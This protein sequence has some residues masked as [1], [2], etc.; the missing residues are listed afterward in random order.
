MNLNEVQ[1]EA[2]GFFLSWY[3]KDLIFFREF[4]RFAKGEKSVEEYSIDYPGSFQDFINSYQ[5]SRTLIKGN[6]ENLLRICKQWHDEDQWLEVNELAATIFNNGIVHGRPISLASKVMFLMRPNEVLPYDKRAR[7]ALGMKNSETD[8]DL[9]RRLAL[10]F[11]DRNKKLIDD[12]LVLAGE[13]LDVLESQ[14]TDL[15]LPM[16]HIRRLRLLDKLL[17]TAGG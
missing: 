15:N 8:Y 9:F 1:I 7:I 13:M 6:T 10:E 11:G 14:F 3:R 2:L 4:Q 17:W 16:Q 12:G 5:I